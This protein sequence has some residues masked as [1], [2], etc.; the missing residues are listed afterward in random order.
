MADRDCRKVNAC[1]RIWKVFDIADDCQ[2]APE[3]AS[4]TSS[5]APSSHGFMQTYND[6]TDINL[7]LKSGTALDHNGVLAVTVCPPAEN[8]DMGRGL[9]GEKEGSISI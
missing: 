6:V 9:A 4:Q 8:R 3:A 2:F 7:R 5:L 1:L